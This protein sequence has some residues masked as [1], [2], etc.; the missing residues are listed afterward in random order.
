VNEGRINVDKSREQGFRMR[1]QK[2]T[3][4][5]RMEKFRLWKISQR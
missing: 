1:K 4:L 3:G 2:S 5:A